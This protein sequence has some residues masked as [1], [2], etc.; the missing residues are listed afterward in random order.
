MPNNDKPRTNSEIDKAVGNLEKIMFIKIDSMEK[1]LFLARQELDRRLEGM[2][3]FR[4]Q[5]RAQ[6]N[7]FVTRE[8]ADTRYMAMEDRLR[9]LEDKR[10]NLEGRMWIIPT[11]IIIIQ[12]IIMIVS[13]IK[14]GS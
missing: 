7:T 10:S 3:E 11:V 13:F 2:N 6:A 12:I 9:S 1:A 4:E 8:I 5:L 14:P